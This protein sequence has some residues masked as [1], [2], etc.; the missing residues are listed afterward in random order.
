MLTG[1]LLDMIT[2][3]VAVDVS[4]LYQIQSAGGNKTNVVGLALGLVIFIWE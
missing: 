1:G 2:K 3:T 4:G